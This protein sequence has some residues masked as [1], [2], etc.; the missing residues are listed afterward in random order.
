MVV[1]E[2]LRAGGEVWW[3][4]KKEERGRNVGKGGDFM[5]RGLAAKRAQARRRQPCSAAKAD[6]GLIFTFKKVLTGAMKGRIGRGGAMEVACRSQERSRPKTFL[7]PT[8][9]TAGR[10]WMKIA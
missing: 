10:I 7:S 2:D 3:R 8:S 9:R 6:H 1:E 5:C 4:R